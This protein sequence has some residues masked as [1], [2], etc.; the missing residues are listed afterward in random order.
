[1]RRQSDKGERG[2]AGW[3]IASVQDFK[4]YIWDLW[5]DGRDDEHGVIVPKIVD[6]LVQVVIKKK[7]RTLYKVRACL[8]A[9]FDKTRSDYCYV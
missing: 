8:K 9:F 6:E 4:V 3:E 1:M 7:K 2:V 5:G